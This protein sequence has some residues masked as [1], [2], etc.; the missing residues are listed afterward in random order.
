ME[1]PQGITDL[2]KTIKNILRPDEYVIVAAQQS[3]ARS[4]VTPDSIFVTNLRIIAYSPSALGLRKSIEDYQYA[5]MA[6]FK[7]S[8]GIMLATLTIRMRYSSD[9]LILGDLPKGKMD[10]ISRV[11]SEGIRRAADKSAPQSVPTKQVAAPQSED[12]QKLLKLRLAKG[13]ITREEFEDMQGLL[14]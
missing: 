11:V 13:E 3:R 2:P 14:D 1:T 8:K 9:D 10:A 4:L 6:N 5:D 7:V 12:P